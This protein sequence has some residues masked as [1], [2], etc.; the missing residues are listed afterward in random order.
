MTM[1]T[2][3]EASKKLPQSRNQMEIYRL[4][5]NRIEAGEKIFLLA[6]GCQRSTEIDDKFLVPYNGWTYGSLDK[7]KQSSDYK[8]VL[9][10]LPLKLKVKYPDKVEVMC[11]DEEDDMRMTQ[12]ALSDIRGF[13][14]FYIRLSE[15]K[16]NP[17]QFS[18]YKSALEEALGKEVQDPI[19]TSREKALESLEKFKYWLEHRNAVFNNEFENFRDHSPILIVGGLHAESLHEG[20]KNTSYKVELITPEGYPAESEKLIEEFT[21]LLKQ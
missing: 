1:T 15:S 8:D 2:D 4:L 12:L 6:E 16:K 13:T 14:S 9:T 20:L 17:K 3:I 18:M 19:K 5:S 11:A 10:M 21:N 7:I